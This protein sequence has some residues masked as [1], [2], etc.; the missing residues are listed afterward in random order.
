MPHDWVTGPTGDMLSGVEKTT[1][2]QEAVTI[3]TGSS[4]P[5]II[6]WCQK[7]IAR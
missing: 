4:R 6:G 1:R 3:L 2:M 5:T 7:E